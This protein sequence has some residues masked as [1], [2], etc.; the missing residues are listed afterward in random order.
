ME[1]LWDG[2]RFFKRLKKKIPEEQLWLLVNGTDEQ[3]DGDEN[4]GKMK[5]LKC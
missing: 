5:F 2:K 3:F 4:C 1:Q